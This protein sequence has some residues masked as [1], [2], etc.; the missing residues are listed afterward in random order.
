MEESHPPPGGE[1]KNVSPLPEKTVG[2]RTVGFFSLVSPEE[3]ET[4]LVLADCPDWEEME[5][6]QGG[7]RL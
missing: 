2:E 1:S 7:F 5:M 4:T 3:V 6:K